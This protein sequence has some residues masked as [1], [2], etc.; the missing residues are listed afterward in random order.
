MKR[1]DFI[2]IVIIL[3]VAAAGLLYM[4]IMNK[5]GDMVIIKVDGKV[6]KELPLNKDATLKIKGAGHGWNELIIKNGKADIVDA[7]CPDKLCVKQRAIEKDGETLVCLPNKV[8][9][10]I[11]SSKESEVDA[12]AN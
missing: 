9:V 5:D 8:I 6:Y 1:N 4:N 10:E 3:A 2:L 7:D 11:E 12:V